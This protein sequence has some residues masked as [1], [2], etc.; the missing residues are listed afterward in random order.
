MT[1]A[2]VSAAAELPPYHVN[3]GNQHPSPTVH[4]TP[5]PNPIVHPTPHPNPGKYDF[6]DRHD[7]EHHHHH[8]HYYDGIYYPDYEW[9]YNPATLVWDWTYV[10]VPIE[11]QPAVPVT[12]EVSATV[13][14]AV[15]DAI[16]N[17]REYVPDPNN[18]LVSVIDTATNEVIDTITVGNYPQAVAVNLDG[19]RAYVANT[20]D[21]TVSVIDTITNTVI[22][23]VSVGS[24]PYQVSVTPDGTSVQVLNGDGSTSW[25]D[26]ATDTVT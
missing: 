15:G 8:D 12:G 9:I 1:A 17:Q 13:Q 3:L 5:H 4:P 10:S 23:T 25:I 7:H 18:N 21:N 20:N 19:T 22:D 2:A 14:P 11:V 24:G 6:H 16:V 26:T